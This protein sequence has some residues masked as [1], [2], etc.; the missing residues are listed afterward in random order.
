MEK[1]IRTKDEIIKNKDETF[2]IVNNVYLK[3]SDNLK[4][5]CD[6]LIAIESCDKEEYTRTYSKMLDFYDI[7]YICEE[8]ETHL[9]ELFGAIWTKG[10]HDEPILKSVCKFDNE[11]P[12]GVLLDQ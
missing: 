11:H 6:E 2:N 9:E 1:Y 12:E 8:N 5:L 10:I 3:Y 4:D 7:V